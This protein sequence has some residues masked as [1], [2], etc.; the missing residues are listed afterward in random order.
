MGK[1]FRKVK[2][3]LIDSHVYPYKDKYNRTTAGLIAQTLRY[4][5]LG[6]G[7][8]LTKNDKNIFKYKDY[9]K[10]KRIF[11]IGNGPSLNKLDLTLLKDEITIGVNSI[12]LAYDK[13]G[14]YPDHLV[15]EDNFVAEDRS[16]ELAEV[17][18]PQK[19][20]G[21]Y[22]RYCLA[23]EDDVNW[24]NV[25]MRYDNYP[26]FPY[27]SYNAGR[28]VWTG[29]SVTYICM[30]LAYYFG[31]SELYLIG[32][33][34][35]YDIPKDAKVEGFKIVSESD[36]PNHFHKDYFGKGY[37]WHDPMVERMEKGYKKASDAFTKHDRI[38]KNATAG[39]KL[40]VIE[41][42]KYESLFEDKSS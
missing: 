13:M 36:D 21:N 11:L 29:G 23:D 10:G 30:Q 1:L 39:G 4:K 5:F 3:K 38:L 15:V 24:L 31:A 33:D 9:A 19:W 35:H 42:V 40:E 41:R 20:Y 22:L 27:F 12:F 32:F 6:R 25:R 18:G 14:F 8:P 7:M 37:R 16:R 2:S 34:H 17:K 26:N 28:C